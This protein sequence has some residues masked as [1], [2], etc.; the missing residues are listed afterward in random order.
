MFLLVSVL[1]CTSRVSVRSGY[2]DN[3]DNDN[4]NENDNDNDHDNENDDDNGNNDNLASHT[5]LHRPNAATSSPWPD[6]LPP[7]GRGDSVGGGGGGV[8]G[9]GG[10]TMTRRFITSR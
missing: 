2:H 1:V 8:D 4:D 3:N 7:N 10:C 5:V 9:G 6:K